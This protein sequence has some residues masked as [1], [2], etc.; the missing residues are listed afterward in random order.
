MKV[1]KQIV[2]DMETLSIVDEISYDYYGSIAKCDGGG[3]GGDGPGIGSGPD[4]PIGG[5]AGSFGGMGQGPIGGVSGPDGRNGV[6]GGPADWNNQQQKVIYKNA[7]GKVAN[8]PS[9][10]DDLDFSGVS[11]SVDDIFLTDDEKAMLDEIEA[12]RVKMLTDAINEKVYDLQ[13]EEISKLVSRGVLQSDVGAESLAKLRDYASEGIEE[14][15]L[16]IGT[17]RMQDELN[18][19]NSKRDFAL[20]EDYL[21]WDMNKFIT[22]L[23][24]QTE[25]SALDRSLAKEINKNLEDAASDANKWGLFGNVVGGAFDLATAIF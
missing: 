23:K 17:Q 5:G 1:Y 11:T 20:K 10:L 9:V 16:A 3:G 13:Q 7:G 15:T 8:Q 4:S 6:G 21:D 2:F 19:L 18:F 12:N 14:G 22:G 24:W 25:Q